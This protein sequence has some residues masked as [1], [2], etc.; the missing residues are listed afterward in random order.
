[1]LATGTR[2]VT[3]CLRGRGWSQEQ[4]LVN[5]PRVLHR[6]RWALLAA[7]PIVLRLL[8]TRFAPAGE[9]VCG[10]DDTR[11]RRRGEHSNAKG[12]YRAPV[13]A[14]QA[15][16]VKARG[17]R[18]RWCLVLV[19][20]AWAGAM[21]GWPCLRVRCA[22]ER[23]HAERGR[24]P[25]KRPERA[26][27]SRRLLTRWVPERLLLCVGA[28]RCAVLARR[29]AVRHI[30]HAWVIPRL[31][32]EAAGWHPA[33]QRQPGHNGRPR[34]QGARCPSPPH[35]LHEPQTPWTTIAGAPG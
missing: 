23:S 10:L 13:R 16:C 14:A 33:P 12:S 6:A 19:T 32:M 15:H 30:P 25:Q 9:V 5:D 7:R 20:V 27:P 24:L 3:A 11:E 21:W 1:M 35:R 22:S 29:H 31:R 26:R 4:G 17:L 34:V 8:G 28:S 18:W 2:T